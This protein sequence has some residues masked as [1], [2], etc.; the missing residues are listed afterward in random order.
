[1][2]AAA[3]CEKD[4]D[5]SQERYTGHGKNQLLWPGVCVV[6]PGGHLALIRQCLCDVENGKRRRN[7]GEDD[8]RAAK[9]DSSKRK[10]GHADSS[11]DFLCTL[12]RTKEQKERLNCACIY[13]FWEPLTRSRACSL[14]VLSS[15]FSRMSSSRNVGLSGF[16]KLRAGV[17]GTFMA[18]LSGDLG[19][20]LEESALLPMYPKPTSPGAALACWTRIW[21][22][23]GSVNG[24]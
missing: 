23:S 18:L 21:S 20:M 8:E 24:E 22:F 2:T 19:A 16:E 3:V 9:V 17:P 11:F 4:N 5:A 13:A 1:M 7:H 10:L 6:G 12:V 14:S 15:R